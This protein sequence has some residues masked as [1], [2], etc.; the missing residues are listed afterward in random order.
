MSIRVLQYRNYY[1]R[2]QKLLDKIW[3]YP[4]IN[5]YIRYVAMNPCAEL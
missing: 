3:V 2:N 4:V 5:I 1:L